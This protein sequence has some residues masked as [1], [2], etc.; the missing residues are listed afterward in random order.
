MAVTAQHGRGVY[1][2]SA[3]VL[4][5]SA[6]LMVGCASSSVTLQDSPQ[7]VAADVTKHPE[8][9]EWTDASSE[10]YGFPK[11]EK[12]LA[13][14]AKRCEMTGLV[15][16]IERDTFVFK[17]AAITDANRAVPGP[18]RSIKYALP[19]QLLCMA[20]AGQPVGESWGFEFSYRHQYRF[21]MAGQNKL[22]DIWIKPVFISGDELAKRAE[23]KRIAAEDAR[24]RIEELN[25]A[26]QVQERNLAEY[27]QRKDAERKSRIPSFRQNVKAGDRMQLSRG[28]AGSTGLVVE[29]KRPL[30][31]VQFDRMTIN[32][33]SIRWLNIEDIEP[34][35]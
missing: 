27:V 18:R 9:V 15:P 16:W 3:F 29:V 8:V 4:L 24:R 28:G 17:P 10:L 22:M 31:L 32:N 25:A 2:L 1:G 30:V 23:A 20:S 12:T 35:H 21:F 19:T 5:G 33:E 14:L 34:S 11:I 13:P 6:A 7:K 26:A